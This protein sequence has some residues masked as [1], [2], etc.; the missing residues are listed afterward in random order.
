MERRHQ[1][2][3][4]GHGDFIRDD[5][6][7]RSADNDAGNNEGV[8]RN[9]RQGDGRDDRDSHAKNAVI[10]ANPRRFGAGKTAQCQDE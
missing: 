6:A 5:R 10:N 2:R 8:W 1:L 3:Q 7:D 4:R 9:L